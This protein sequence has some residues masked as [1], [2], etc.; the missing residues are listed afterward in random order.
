M[1]IVY[2]AI[3]ICFMFNT[4][5]GQD[6][7][8][9]KNV[10]VMEQKFLKAEKKGKGENYDI[11]ELSFKIAECYRQKKDTNSFKWYRKTIATGKTA[12]KECDRYKAQAARNTIFR[13]G[14]AYYYTGNY[15][16][17]VKYFEKLQAVSANPEWHYFLALNYIKLRRCDIAA[18]ELEN[19]KNRSADPRDAG[20][21][22]DSCQV[23]SGK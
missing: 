19:F 22:L 4:A 11:T 8:E 1:K 15:E 17:S 2:Y 10:S 6:H 18:I 23:N 7:C 5:R 21:L 16:E 20:Q 12:I 13:I 14:Q 3:I 9:A